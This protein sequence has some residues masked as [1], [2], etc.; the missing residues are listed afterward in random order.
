M[1]FVVL[2]AIFTGLC[3]ILVSEVNV[4]SRIL[5]VPQA[6]EKLQLSPDIVREYLREGKLPGRKIG[7][8]WRILESD[9]ERWV[10]RGQFDRLSESE[11]LERIASMRGMLK[12]FPG[13]PLTNEDVI[14]E[15]R[16]EVR[17]EDEKM[18][19]AHARV[20]KSA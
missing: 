17:L 3:G 9:L 14:A 12:R 11:R 1:L 18:Q 5:T 8:V 4:M 2:Y 20:R 7:K 10:S 6:A 13:K 16:A 19:R 15:K